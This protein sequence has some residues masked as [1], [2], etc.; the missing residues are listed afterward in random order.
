MRT[1]HLLL[2]LIVALSCTLAWPEQPPSGNPQAGGAAAGGPW[3]FAVSGDSRNCG[4]LVMPAIAASARRENAQFYWHLG[5]FRAISD[6]DEDFLAESQ[7]SGKRPRILAYEQ[8][9]WDD[10]IAHQLRP[11]GD[12][13]VFLGIGNHET[14]P[15]KDRAQFVIQFADWLDSPVVRQQR[16][17][18]D[19]DDHKLKTY[20]HWQQGGVDFINLDNA[21]PEQFDSAQMAWLERVLAADAQ[22]R[23]G[24]STIVAGMHEALPD[25]LTAAHSMNNSPAAEQS[26]RRAY[27][28][29]LAQ[30]RSG[31]RVYV[32]A[33]H[34]HFFM[35]GIFNTEALQQ[36][37]AVLP[38]WIIGNAGA[39]R[40]PLPDNAGRA[41]AAAT[42]V[43]GYLLAT[44]NPPGQPLGTVAFQFKEVA[45]KDISATIVSEFSEPLVRFCFDENSEAP[46]K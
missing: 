43:Y 18:D 4:N 34:S 12:I 45:R 22:P 5:D 13:P 23:S 20:Y 38:G 17:A 3:K 39:V 14:V 6:F 26:G 42:N 10:F 8:V 1:R 19:P 11:F 41:R 36:R 32:V 31:K 33:S 28:L 27:E 15:P 24:V 44:V 25:S 30:Q 37:D 40:R 9:A 21:S 46:R 7:Y 29:L 2:V 35:D 16:L